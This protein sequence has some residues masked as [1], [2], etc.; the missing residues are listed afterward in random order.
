ML[1]SNLFL[2]AFASCCIPFTLSLSTPSFY[3]SLPPLSLPSSPKPVLVKFGGNAMTTPELLKSFCEDCAYLRSRRVPLVVVH[4]GG[5]M[6]TGLLKRLQIEGEFDQETGVR[7]SSAEVVSAA[8]MALGSVGKGLAQ[9][10]STPEHPAISLSG[11]D[12]RLLKCS[13]T[14]PRL[15]NVGTVEVRGRHALMIALELAKDICSN[16]SLRSPPLVRRNL[17]PGRLHVK[18]MGSSDIPHR[19]LSGRL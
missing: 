11:R 17:P 15:G 7:V 5:P 18:R 16:K 14:D 2:Y 6:I 10:I 13:R 8:E 19:M 4:G 9:S 1:S 3:S 12:G